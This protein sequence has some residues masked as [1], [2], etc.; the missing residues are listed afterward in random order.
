MS[1]NFVPSFRPTRFR[2][3][4]KVQESLERRVAKKIKKK[5]VSSQ[6]KAKSFNRIESGALLY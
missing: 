5:S 1:S 3:P 4:E 6:R 2:D